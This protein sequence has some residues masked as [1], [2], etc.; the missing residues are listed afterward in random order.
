MFGSPVPDP[1]RYEHPATE[2]ETTEPPGGYAHMPPSAPDPVEGSTAPMTGDVPPMGTPSSVHRFDPWNYRENSG[3]G[4]GADLIGYRVEAMDG[5]IGKIDEASTLVGDSYLV[6]DTGPWIFGKKV[7]LPAGTV[8]NIDHAGRSLFVDRTKGQIKDS[9]EYDP[10]SFRDE[11]YRDKVG[12]YYHGT[13]QAT[14]YLPPGARPDPSGT[15]RDRD[16]DIP[17]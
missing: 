8:T 6:V 9:P 10:E 3:I 14:D 4:D 13:Y 16:E 11:T 7:L 2:P 15:A 1:Q 5:H 17:R 12:N